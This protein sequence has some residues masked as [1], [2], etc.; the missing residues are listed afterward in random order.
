ML[1]LELANAIT[2]DR[3]RSIEEDLRLRL[4]RK[5]SEAKRRDERSAALAAPPVASVPAPLVE[6]RSR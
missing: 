2:R 3:Q 6:A 1:S 5:A 4:L